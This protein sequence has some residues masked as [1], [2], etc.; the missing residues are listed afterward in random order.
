[1]LCTEFIYHFLFPCIVY[2]MSALKQ[3]WTHSDQQDNI[4]IPNLFCRRNQNVQDIIT[5]L[6]LGHKCFEQFDI[7][8]RFHH[9]FFLGDLNYRMEEEIKPT[10][11]TY[12]MM[13]LFRNY[14]TNEFMQ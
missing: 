4:L 12:L 2:E 9:L 7:T 5:H 10:V 13:T 11:C 6:N 14:D 3:L 1:M 8:N